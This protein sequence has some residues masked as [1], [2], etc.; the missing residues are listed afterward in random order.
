MIV[1]LDADLAE[2][3]LVAGRIGCP[4]CGGPLRPWSWARP[5]RVRRLDGSAGV[6]R[7]RR[8][9]CRDCRATRVLLP[10]W[11]QPRLADATEV[12]GAALAAKTA[13]QGHRRIAAGLGRATSTVRRW[14]RRARDRDHLERLRRRGVE[15]VAQLDPEVLATGPWPQPSAL[16]DALEALAAAVFAWRH[17]WGREVDGWALIGVFTGGRLLADPHFDDQHRG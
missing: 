15:R 5:R 6:V 10:S 12:I 3:D 17:R 1:V 14:L 16:G 9:R 13:G 11:C 4:R 2:A 8:G 7:P